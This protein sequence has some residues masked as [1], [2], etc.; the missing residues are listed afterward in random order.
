VEATILRNFSFCGHY[1]VGPVIKRQLKI[2]LFVDLE[3]GQAVELVA[4][5]D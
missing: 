2:S 3:P 5:A 1:L 4:A